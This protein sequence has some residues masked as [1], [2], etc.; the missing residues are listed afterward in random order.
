MKGKKKSFTCLGI[1]VARLP[2]LRRARG[3]PAQNM[4]TRGVA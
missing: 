3:I 2:L 4:T 1:V